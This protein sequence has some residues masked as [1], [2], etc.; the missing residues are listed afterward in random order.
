[1]SR[2]I[3]ASFWEAMATN[4][5]RHAATWLHPAFEYFMP[6]SGE[7]LRGR[8]AFAV[9]NELYPANGP[10]RFDVRSIMAEG[11]AAVSDVVVTAGTMIARAI[12]FH[13]LRDG[14]ILRQKEFWPDNYAAPA[15]R[16]HLTQIVDRE[17]F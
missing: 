7:Y 12:T 9:V 4:D 15:W 16:H 2:H 10:W 13:T 1:M 5:F 8:E 3:I 14:L 11:D 17:P 6:Q